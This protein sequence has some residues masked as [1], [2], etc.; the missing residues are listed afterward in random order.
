VKE[1]TSITGAIANEFKVLM[2]KIAVAG[3]DANLLEAVG[4]SEYQISMGVPHTTKEGQG[5][6]YTIGDKIYYIGLVVQ[7]DERGIKAPP[8][9]EE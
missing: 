2:K 5:S 4:Q 8:H 3:G 6:L 9:E 7:I 1:Q